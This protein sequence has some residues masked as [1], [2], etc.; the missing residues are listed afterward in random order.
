MPVSR[1]SAYR[2]NN[3]LWFNRLLRITYGLYIRH[4]YRISLVGLEVFDSLKPPYVIV[5]NHVAMLDAFLVGSF[6]PTPVYWIASDSN[7]RTTIMRAL[8][9]LVGTIPKS[10]FIPD[11]ET[12]NAIVEV[13][14]KRHGVVGIFPEGSASFDGHTQDV[15][16]A[17]GKLLRLLKVPVVVVLLKG[18]FSTMPCWSWRHKRGRIELEFKIALSAAQTKSLSADESYRR[19]VDAL[20]YDED[21]WLAENKVAFSGSHR[22]E[23]LETVLFQCPGCGRTD[24]MRSAGALFSC[25]ACGNAYRMDH[26]NRLHPVSDPTGS[27]I[28]IRDWSL[29]QG[30]RFAVVLR[31]Q[32][33]ADPEAALFADDGVVVLRG[34]KLNP[35]RRFQAGRLSF[36]PD[37]IELRTVRGATVRFDLAEIDGEGVFKRNM[38]EFYHRR[39]LY[40]VHF[41]TRQASARRWLMAI[42]ILRDLAESPAGRAA[43]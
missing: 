31:R 34:K 27:V 23:H 7:M 5:P 18:A 33:A 2:P 14:R 4:R 41:A 36:F 11:L 30:D 26:Y 43:Q 32:A 38:L 15:V 24:S 20:E 16:P 12:I 1:K 17:T 19:L 42:K 28:T 39:V 13:I 6:V 40:Q 8:L 10:K 22:A 29:R 3:P 37:R 9:R 25:A 21:Q 35:L